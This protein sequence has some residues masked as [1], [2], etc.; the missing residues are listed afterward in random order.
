M[1]LTH[2]QMG[3]VAQSFIILE[4]RPQFACNFW[5]EKTNKNK[6]FNSNFQRLSRQIP[7]SS[8]SLNFRKRSEFRTSWTALICTCGRVAQR[9]ASLF[10][11]EGE[12]MSYKEP[13]N[14]NSFA[15]HPFSI[16]WLNIV[17]SI[18][19][20]STYLS[21]RGALNKLVD[22]PPPPKKKLFACD[23]L[24]SA[25]DLQRQLPTRVDKPSR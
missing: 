2:L 18:I 25:N 15:W 13:H 12:S 6:A 21:S 16:N 4:K 8:K 22:N 7:F 17:E 1:I 20:L 19:V 9:Q 24:K 3:P 10:E 23:T 11:Q 14:S 5:E